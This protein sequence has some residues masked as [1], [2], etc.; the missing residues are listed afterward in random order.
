M[1]VMLTIEYTLKNIRFYLDFI[2]KDIYTMINYY[3]IYIIKTFI[4]CIYFRL[5]LA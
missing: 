5:Y 3:S 4:I 1:I 2:R